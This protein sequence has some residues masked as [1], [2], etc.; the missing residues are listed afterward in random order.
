M[1]CG[2]HGA[3]GVRVLSHVVAEHIHEREHALHLPQLTV[4]ETVQEPVSIPVPAR[5][6]LNAQ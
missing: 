3:P 4:D 5:S 6:L 2:P 1:G